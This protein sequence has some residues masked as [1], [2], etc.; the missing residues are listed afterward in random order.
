MWV[1]GKKI[2]LR[3]TKGLSSQVPSGDS[4]SSGRIE[5]ASLQGHSMQAWKRQPL[6][7]ALPSPGTHR[8]TAMTRGMLRPRFAGAALACLD[9]RKC[10]G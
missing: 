9:V 1:D 8:Q 3:L 2:T 4:A 7:L 6:D 5:G 10:R